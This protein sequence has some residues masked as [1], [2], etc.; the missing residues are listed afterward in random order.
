[1]PSRVPWYESLFVLLVIFAP[2]LAMVAMMFW[3]K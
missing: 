2:F 1:M 3:Y